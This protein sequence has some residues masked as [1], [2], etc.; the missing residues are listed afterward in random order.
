MK[1]FC[2]GS[3]FVSFSGCAKRNK[4]NREAAA[5]RFCK[6]FNSTIKFVIQ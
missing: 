5:S 4:K 6:K 3:W 1:T 2:K